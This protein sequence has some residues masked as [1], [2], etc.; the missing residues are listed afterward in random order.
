MTKLDSLVEK[1]L[2]LRAQ[3][4]D[5]NEK[6]DEVQANKASLEAELMERMSQAGATTLGTK[7]GTASLKQSKKF[8]I[9]DWDNLLKYIVET[10]SFDILQRRIAANAVKDRVNNEE[11]VP[12]I[13]GVDVYS[14]SIRTK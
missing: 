6:L 10:E 4:S 1:I 5:L 9:T 7:Y 13:T 12:G 8:V 11:D 14:V 2:E 3:V